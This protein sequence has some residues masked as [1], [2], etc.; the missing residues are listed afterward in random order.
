MQI[1][2]ARLPTITKRNM[3]SAESKSAPQYPI[4]HS[5]ISYTSPT[6]KLQTLDLWL[7]RAPSRSDPHATTWVIYVHGGAWRDPMQDSRCVQPTI[8]HLEQGHA[9]ALEK[10]AGI[11]SIN[12]RLS[13]YPSHPT[14]PS[15]P[16]DPQRNVRHPHHVQDVHSAI[17]CLKKEHGLARWI[18]VGHSCGATLLLQ[19][20]AGIGLS[21]PCSTLP[22]ALILLEGIYSIP[23]LLRNHL[24]PSC[25][26]NISRI[27]HEFI[28]GAFGDSSTFDAQ[29]PV[30][31][32]YTES[33][34]P[35][36][37]LVVLGHSAEDELLE[38]AQRD[39][40][41]AK[42]KDEGW[43]DAGPATRT[44]QIRDLAGGHDEIWEDGLQI[45]GLI[46]DAVRFVHSD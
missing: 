10:I 41:L 14:D 8:K 2:F 21:Q 6:S 25:P 42:L 39:V 46:N 27:Y 16:D 26:E 13:P 22:E 36:A 4:Y 19:L 12:Y 23:L 11:A 7:P 37:K 44:V 31:G 28:E 17:E 45:A 5:A 43:K 40:M 20:V 24:P 18:G 9:D 32:M 34:W 35:G 15:K 30:S 3:P 33:A 29:S 1:P 38:V